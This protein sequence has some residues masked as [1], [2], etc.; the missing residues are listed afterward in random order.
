[1]ISSMLK[2]ELGFG[3]A[4]GVVCYSRVYGFNAD[5]VIRCAGYLHLRQPPDHVLEGSVQASYQLRDGVH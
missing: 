1:M 5:R 2:G 4:Y 3:V